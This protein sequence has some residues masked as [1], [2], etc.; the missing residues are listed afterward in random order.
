M[1]TMNYSTGTG[2]VEGAP[3]TA[4][5]RGLRRDR[6]FLMVVIGAALMS[7]K[8]RCLTSKV[9]TNH[10]FKAFFRGRK[11]AYASIELLPE[12]LPPDIIATIVQHIAAIGAIHATHIAIT[13]P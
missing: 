12:P 8:R 7:G 6:P 4:R 3:S 1:S 13:Q 5:M 9:G 2:A 10:T 11:Y